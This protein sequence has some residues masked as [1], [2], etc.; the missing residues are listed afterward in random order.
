MNK[1]TTILI[2]FWNGHEYIERLLES[3]PPQFEVLVIDDQSD[4]PLQLNREY[5]NVKVIHL[6]KKGY[7]SGAVNEGI[8]RSRGDILVL[9][10]DS[11]LEG[12]EWLSI[13]AAPENY[14]ISG[15]GVFNHPAWPQGYVQGTFM[16]LKRSAIEKVGLLNENLYPLWGSTCEWQLRACR[17]GLEA[18]PFSS[19]PGFHHLRHKTTS[20]GSSIREALSREME[21]RDWFIRTP[22]MISVVIPAYNHGQYLKDCIN[23]L[24]GGTTVLGRSKGQTLQAFEIIVVDDASTDETPEIMAELVDPWKAIRY[25]RRETNGGTPAANN[26]GIRAAFGKYI[27]ILC[28]DDMR[29]EN[30]LEE[31]YKAQVKNEHSFIYDDMLWF[32]NARSK[33]IHRMPDFDFDALLEKNHVHCGIMFPRAAWSEVGG[34][35]EVMRH[36]REDWAMNVNLGMSGYCGVHISNVGYLYRRAGQNRTLK[37]TTPDWRARFK[38]QIEELFP[39]LYGGER[40]MACCGGSRNGNR[41]SSSGPGTKEIPLVG[42]LGMTVVE[43]LGE[44]YGK[45]TFWGPVTGQAYTFSAAQKRRNVDNRDLQTLNGT[46]LLDLYENRRRLFRIAPH[47]TPVPEAVTAPLPMPAPEPISEDH[48]VFSPVEEPPVKPKKTGRPKKKD[49]A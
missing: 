41:P 36:G 31:L 45:Q 47:P 24:I 42:V 5:R 34:Y 21:K 10:Q 11:W 22:P 26:T 13:L 9:N 15:D 32:A 28:G 3:I 48:V 46:G 1:A 7:F 38:Q 40:P 37:N 33:E 18:L 39:Q 29:S 25:I 27:T 35:P 43:Y 8:R 44:N 49:Q 2:P 17:L 16:L 12:R 30:A 4:E 23:S 20:F 19:I 14:A 6:E